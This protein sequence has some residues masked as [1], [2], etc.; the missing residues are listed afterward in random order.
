V[1]IC[2]LPHGHGDGSDGRQSLSNRY[3]TDVTIVKRRLTDV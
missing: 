3:V 1:R 2:T